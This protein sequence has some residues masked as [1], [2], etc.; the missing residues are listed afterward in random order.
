MFVFALARWHMYKFACPSQHMPVVLPQKKRGAIPV[1]IASTS[2]ALLV[3]LS[4][5]AACHTVVPRLQAFAV[6]PVVKYSRLQP[7][8]L[9]SSWLAALLA[10]PVLMTS[11]CAIWW[12]C[13]A[14]IPVKHR[15]RLLHKGSGAPLC[16]CAHHAQGDK[17][18]MAVD[19][20]CQPTTPDAC[21]MA[22]DC[23]W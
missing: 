11:S 10:S 23:C 18:D 17:G 19:C 14:A 2:D 15:V 9:Q 22:V 7:V 20:L 3:L 5:H 1:T 6:I 4:P 12:P 13:S 8:L 16:V 21:A